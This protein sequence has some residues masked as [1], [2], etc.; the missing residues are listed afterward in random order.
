MAYENQ[1]MEI[2][3]KSNLTEML[4]RLI[5]DKGWKIKEVAERW[6]LTPRR[7]SQILADPSYKEIDAIYGLPKK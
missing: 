2:E 3:R 7:M 4:K 6:E 5:K 1:E